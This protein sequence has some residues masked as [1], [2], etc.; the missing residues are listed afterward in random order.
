[1]IWPEGGQRQLRAPPCGK[2]VFDANDTADEKPGKGQGRSSWCVPETKP[3][4]V[5]GMIACQGYFDQPRR[6][7]HSAMP[8]SLRVSFGIPG[9]RAAAEELR[10]RR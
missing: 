5:H 7:L 1:M 10:N 9:G 6:T 8:L 3:D 2:A 4:D